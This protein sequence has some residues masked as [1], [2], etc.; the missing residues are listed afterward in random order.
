MALVDALRRLPAGQRNALALHYVLGLSLADIAGET[1]A[2]IGTVKARL[3][4]GRAALAA[5]LR[6]DDQRSEVEA[7]H[8]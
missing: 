6:E 1:N 2:P 8:G 4:R 3:A 7:N 5:L